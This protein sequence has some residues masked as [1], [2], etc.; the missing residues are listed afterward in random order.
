MLHSYDDYACFC[1]F[2]LFYACGG[3]ILKTFILIKIWHSKMKKKSTPILFDDC[4]CCC[5][6]GNHWIKHNGRRV[7]NT[8][9]PTLWLIDNPSKS[10]LMLD[11]W[12]RIRYKSI[13]FDH[14]HYYCSLAKTHWKLNQEFR[15]NWNE[16]YTR[17]HK[18]KLNIKKKLLIK[19]W[20]ESIF[21]FDDHQ[22]LLMDNNN[23]LLLYVC[24]FFRWI[25]SINCGY[26][27]THTNTSIM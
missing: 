8:H 14:H 26:T 22:N 27:H 3:Y 4:C 25:H 20:K 13:E 17:K 16:T 23:I 6:F 19:K 18:H 5:C 21:V 2:D 9:L 24:M 7:Q 12:H 15:R 11:W 1:F 10:W